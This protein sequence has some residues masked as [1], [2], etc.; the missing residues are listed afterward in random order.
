MKLKLTKEAGEDVSVFSDK[1]V[2]I[3]HHIGGLSHTPVSDLHTLIYQCYEESD[4]FKA[5]KETKDWEANVMILRS[6]YRDLVNRS[7]WIALKHMKEKV[8]GL[9]GRTFKIHSQ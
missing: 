9:Q 7:S 5:V 4:Y 6:M 1:V 3:A 8:E 2:G